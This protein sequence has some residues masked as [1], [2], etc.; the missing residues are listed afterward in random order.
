MIELIFDLIPVALAI[1]T[2]IL[3]SRRYSELRRQKD[4]V[5]FFFAII[6]CTVMLVAQLSWWSTNYLK[7]ELFDFTFANI[8]WTLFNSL[9]M[10]IFII[11]ALPRK[12]E[13]DNS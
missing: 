9:V 1:V 12:N 8:L 5:V 6:S 4:R 13:T 11:L 7:A 2:I 3:M 10:I